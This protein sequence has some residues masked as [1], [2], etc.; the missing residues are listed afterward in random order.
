LCP[1]RRGAGPVSGAKAKR[2]AETAEQA[3]AARLA[4]VEE[5]AKA[6]RLADEAERK[7]RRTHG[8]EPTEA[9]RRLIRSLVMV[10]ILQQDICTILDIA[11]TT[12]N[13]HFRRELDT[14]YIEIV[15]QMRSK[16]LT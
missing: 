4:E 6:A 5:K 8:Y 7:R 14:G 10:G 15:R 12:L 1:M 3:E 2:K 9:D 16:L 13:R 11:W